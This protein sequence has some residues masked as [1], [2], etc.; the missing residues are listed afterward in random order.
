[1][2]FKAQGAHIAVAGDL[3][4]DVVLLPGAWVS[5]WTH[6]AVEVLTVDDRWVAFAP[7][8]TLFTAL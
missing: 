2:K 8:P 1:M 3:K 4:V 7:T 5:R 6:A